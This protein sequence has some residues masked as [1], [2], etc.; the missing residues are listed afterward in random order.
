[1]RSRYFSA[2]AEF[3][4][5]KTDMCVCMLACRRWV[6]GQ[7]DGQACRRVWKSLRRYGGTLEYK[8]GFESIND[9]GKPMLEGVPTCIR[10][11]S[12]D[13]A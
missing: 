5:D 11:E 12:E 3:V 7:P 1:M 2:P 9:V 13:Q 10:H 8:F 6:A 4:G